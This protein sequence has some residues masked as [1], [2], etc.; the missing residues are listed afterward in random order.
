MKITPQGNFDHKTGQVVVVGAS[1]GGLNALINLIQQL[2]ADFPAP[3]LIVMH[4]SPDATGNV[5]LDALNKN[6]KLK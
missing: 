1:A 6:G 5:L 4:I 2:P 3:V